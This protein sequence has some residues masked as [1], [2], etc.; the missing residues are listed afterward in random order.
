MGIEIKGIEEIARRLRLAER[1][2][3]EAAKS[4]VYGQA[5]ALAELANRKGMVPVQSGRLRASLYITT[6]Q[7][8]GNGVAVELGYG[9]EYAPAVHERS[10]RPG[11]GQPRWLERAANIHARALQVRLRDSL[12]AA[13]RT[14]VVV[15][16]L[17][18]GIPTRPPPAG[19][20]G[21]YQRKRGFT[22]DTARAISRLRRSGALK[23][24]RRWKKRRRK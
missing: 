6:P 11:Q 17:T 24:V 5:V 3:E 7:R 20:V 1:T 2:V 19:P 13:L 12:A 15:A 23:L 9:A 14:G 10:A 16:P 18:T 4:A 21:A 22:K 8:I